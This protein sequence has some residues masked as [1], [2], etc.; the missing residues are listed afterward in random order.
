MPQH[1]RRTR[2]CRDCDGHA[3]A[4]ITTG[5]RRPDGTHHTLTVLCPACKGTGHTAPAAGLA[6]VGK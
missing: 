4:H 1:A 2:V 6:R 3:T 5:T